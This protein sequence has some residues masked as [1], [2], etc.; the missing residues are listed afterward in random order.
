MVYAAAAVVSSPVWGYR[1]WRTGKWRTDWQGR[2]G[3]TPRMKPA[4]A[5]V[6]TI[7]ICAVSVG[8]VN[9]IR[10]LVGKLGQSGE[11]TLRIIIAVTTD[12]GF[13]RATELYGAQHQVVRYP[14]DFTA[15]VRRFLDA[16]QPDLVALVELEVW[17]NFL[18]QCERRRIPVCVIN[19]RL[20]ERSFKNYCKIKPLLRSTFA[21]LAAVGAQTREYAERFVHMGTAGQRVM[22]LDSM[23]WDTAQVVPEG[24]DAAELIPGAMQLAEQLGLDRNR[25]IIV[26]G[27]TAPGEDKLLIDSCPT[28]VQLVIVPRKPEWFDLVAE[29]AP[30]IVR[31]TQHRE[32]IRPMDGARL[33]LLDTVGEL[34]KAYA[35]ADVCIVGRSFLGLY[36]SDMMEPVALGKPTIVGPYHSDFQ[37][38]VDALK[39]AEGIIITDQPGQVAG[40]LLGDRAKASLLANRGRQVI[41][42]RQ[43]VTERYVR[44]MMNAMTKTDT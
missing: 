30:N 41:V 17:P 11:Q 22:V 18:L 5:E 2:F 20:S 16:T 39:A 3:H 21:R 12:T 23:K 34:R 31:R 8:E 36:G 29:Q 40:E 13:A 35:L 26:A 33:F 44:L 25:P 15:S 42:Q 19:G 6:K 24:K 27:S 28:E 10:Q 37:D 1:L 14:L 9:A 38:T 4:A 43:G 32:G 7:L